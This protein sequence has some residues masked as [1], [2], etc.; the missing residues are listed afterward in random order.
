MRTQ[1][2]GSQHSGGP[3]ELHGSKGNKIPR[4]L[5]A[6]ANKR[7]PPEGEV[8]ASSLQPQEPPSNGQLGFLNTHVRA[9]LAERRPSGADTA[10]REACLQ[11]LQAVVRKA[12]PGWSLE[13]FGSLASNFG[14]SSSDVDVTCVQP[15]QPWQAHAAARFLKES[16]VPLIQEHPRLTVSEEVFSAKVPIL[17]LC[18]DGQLDIDLSCQNTYA[19]RNTR[20]LRAYANIDQR[21]QELGVAVKLWAKAVGLCGAAQGNLS[22][23]AFT[24]LVIYFMQVHPDVLLPCLPTYAFEEGMAGESDS[25]VRELSCSWNRSLSLA[26]LLGRFFWFYTR[27]F[28]WG[29]EVVSPRLGR[30]LSATD[31][32]FRQL[33]G[34]YASRLQVEDP[35]RLERNLH[36]VLGEMEE[37]RLKEALEQ[38]LCAILRGQVP[39][40]LR[41]QRCPPAE[42]PASPP[43]TAVTVSKAA[44]DRD[45]SPQDSSAG[46]TA[47]GEETKDGT[48][49]AGSFSRGS[50]QP[51]D[52][53]V[54]AVQP[55]RWK[56]RS[57]SSLVASEQEAP[58]PDG[59]PGARAPGKAGGERAQDERREEDEEDMR[60]EE[61]YE[62]DEGTPHSRVTPA[63]RRGV[64]EAPT[65][66]EAPPPGGQERRHNPVPAAGAVTAEARPDRCARPAA[67]SSVRA[68]LGRGRQP[69]EHH[70]GPGLQTTHRQRRLWRA[71]EMEPAIREHSRDHGA[72][73]DAGG[74]VEDDA[75]RSHSALAIPRTATSTGR[76]SHHNR[77]VAEA[78]AAGRGIAAEDAKQCA[79]V[80][81]RQPVCLTVQDF[82]DKMGRAAGPPSAASP[83][84]AFAAPST[85][86]IASRVSKACLAR[87]S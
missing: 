85:N 15:D 71:G 30:R 82:E 59:W 9:L 36:H 12:G 72:C 25:R 68:P 62:L 80:Q 35:F 2:H 7:P 10:M 78:G 51:S 13:L 43:S 14:T 48:S 45:G 1:Q 40:G 16:I 11:E 23:Y 50:S 21:V 38:A 41:C 42:E 70:R 28:T 74:N 58:G 86:K 24:L 29:Q 75:P 17:R 79:H 34:R 18:F 22:S 19:V 57:S 31:Q 77:W 6:T 63:A 3:R 61:P 4:N 47:S 76:R 39:V 60:A 53:D 44:A 66:P 20:Y 64:W 65:H 69:R 26:E 87:A 54:A 49:P 27:A 5:V 52:E 81:E 55:A 56:R 67:G 8:V 37:A 33:R 46:S 84:R 73:G 32:Q 83:I